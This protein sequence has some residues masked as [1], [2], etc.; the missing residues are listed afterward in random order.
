MDEGVVGG[1]T[2][3]LVRGLDYYAFVKCDG[4]I[5]NMSCQ[6]VIEE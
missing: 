5:H 3:C 4:C 6:L 2:L 1:G